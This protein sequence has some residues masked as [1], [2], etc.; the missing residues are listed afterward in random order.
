MMWV[1]SVPFIYLLHLNACVWDFTLFSL[2]LKSKLTTMKHW[3]KSVP[4]VEKHKQIS[5]VT[6]QYWLS[7]LSKISLKKFLRS[8]PS[9]NARHRVRQRDVHHSADVLEEVLVSNQVEKLK[10]LPHLKSNSQR[11]DT[12]D[13]G[14]LP[15]H[16]EHEP[17]DGLSWS[18]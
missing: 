15:N 14:L 2:V 10:R 17:G 3:L 18:E 11:A 7:P 16:V 8:N 12:E 1:F 9:P 4:R 6:F 5:F 13:A